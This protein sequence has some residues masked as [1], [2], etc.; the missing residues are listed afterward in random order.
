MWPQVNPR[1]SSHRSNSGPV[2]PAWTRTSPVSGSRC[3]TAFI[4]QKPTPTV[5]RSVTSTPSTTDVPPPN[6]TT[7]QPLAPARSRIA[8]TW[9][10]SRGSSTAST[11]GN[12]CPGQRRLHRSMNE[13]PPEQRSLTRSSVSHSHASPARS[14]AAI[15]PARTGTAAM[16]TAGRGSTPPIPRS[17][18]NSC[19]LRGTPCPPSPHRCTISVDKAMR[20]PGS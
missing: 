7:A 13:K 5:N 20:P 2:M 10:W 16:S 4:S 1:A 9:S 18:R 8:R 19:R 3:C 14:A 15:R 17:A 12:S 6:G 11:T